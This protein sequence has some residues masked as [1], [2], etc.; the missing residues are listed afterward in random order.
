M[1]K[2]KEVKLLKVSLRV[3]KRS[4]MA[5]KRLADIVKGLANYF[6]K[7]NINKEEIKGDIENV[8]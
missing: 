8:N 1:S 5:L 2:R 4:A 7:P 3:I 6:I